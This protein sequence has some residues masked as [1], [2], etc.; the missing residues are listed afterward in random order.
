MRDKEKEIYDFIISECDLC[1]SDLPEKN[2]DADLGR[3]TRFAALSLKCRAA[4]Y[5]ASIAEFGTVQLDG[6]VGIP[7]DDAEG[8][9]KTAYDAASKIISS[10][11]SSIA[12]S[13]TP[14]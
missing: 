5:A 11:Q 4:L 7:A 8:Y 9:Y 1:C 3:A 14:C 12:P 10:G 6:L 13:M 2:T